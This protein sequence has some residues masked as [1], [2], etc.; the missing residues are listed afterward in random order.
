MLFSFFVGFQM[1]DLQNKQG[2]LKNMTLRGVWPPLKS[3]FVWCLLANLRLVWPL[4][5]KSQKNIKWNYLSEGQSPLKVIFFGCVL[6][7][8]EDLAFGSRLHKPDLQHILR[9]LKK[10]TARGGWPPLKGNFVR[11]CFCFCDFER[12]AQKRR[13]SAPCESP[14]RLCFF[15]FLVGFPKPE[16]QK[17]NWL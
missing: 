6:V 7:L 4:F 12:R 3:N 9:K 1:P 2:N 13:R 15:G 14:E 10:M 5:S 8:F 17:K 16:L 11:Y